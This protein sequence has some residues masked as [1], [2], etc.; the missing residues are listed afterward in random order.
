MADRQSRGHAARWAGTSAAYNVAWHG[1]HLHLHLTR[2]LVC[3][4]RGLALGVWHGWRWV[5]DRDD[6]G[7]HHS[8]VDAAARRDQKA[9]ATMA[10]IRK[11]RVR[12]RLLGIVVSAAVLAIL[13]VIVRL[14]WPPGLWILAAAAVAALAY[15]GRPRNAPLLERATVSQEVQRVTPDIVARALGS[16]GLASI[17]QHLGRNGDIRVMVGRDGPGWHVDAELPIGTTATDVAERRERLASG[18]R[19]PL[20]AVWPEPAR[21]GHAGLLHVFVGDVAMSKARQ[22]PWPLAKA[23][24]ADIF[25]AM[26]FGTDPRGRNVALPLMYSNLLTGGL[27]GSGK[28]MATRVIL[29]GAALD[30]TCEI[31]C[32]ELAGR[33]DLAAFEKVAYRYGCGVDDGTIADCL[34]DLRDVHAELEHR[35]KVLAGLPRDLIPENKVTRQIAGK[36]SLRLH[37]MV[38]AIS[39]CQELFAHPVHGTEAGDLCTAIIKR[40]RALAVMLVLDTKR[41]DAKSLPTGVS[42]NAGTRYGL[43]I[44][45]S[46]TNDRL[47][48]AGTYKAGIRATEFTPDDL[49]IGLLIGAGPVPQIARSYYID[50]PGADRIAARARAAREAAGTLAGY[51]AGDAPEASAKVSL[52]ADVAAV[53][54]EPKQHLVT[55]AAR[56]AELRPG[57]YGGWDERQAGAALR[58]QGVTPGQMWIEG[59]NLNGVERDAVIAAAGDRHA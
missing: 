35:A 4:P 18:L 7:T 47:L 3:A 20:G 42:V 34:A 41:P 28:T 59:K 43:R 2:V 32:W 52:L 26:P 12:T 16:L 17:S 27:P 31:R 14:A 15:L 49:G 9:Y 58:A 45:D 13:A 51:C 33:G 40:G 30:P 24:T 10:R 5:F 57:L 6:A 11:D 23:G 39:E 22:A 19:R 36:R 38:V 8:R 29:L 37:P 53:M 50:A 56:L 44:M 46:D 55:I 54:P 21:D 48:G 25:L 1:L